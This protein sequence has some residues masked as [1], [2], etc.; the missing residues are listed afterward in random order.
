MNITII[1]GSNP[2]YKNQNYTTD[3]AVKLIGLDHTVILIK[4]KE[5]KINY[6]NGCWGCWCKT[7]GECVIRDDMDEICRAYIHSDLVLHFSPLEMGFVTS[8]MKTINDR[9]IQLVHPY[10]EMVNGEIHH[11]K[12][13]ENYPL[14]GL[15]VD[16]LES[17]DEDLQITKDLYFRMAINFKTQLKIFSTTK[18]TQEEL[19]HEISHI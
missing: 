4:A 19:I 8:R 7:P 6:C 5:K 18:K 16:P 15:I 1:D 2:D 9:T 17:D 10:F 14:L 13:Y 3:L 11:Q 12:R